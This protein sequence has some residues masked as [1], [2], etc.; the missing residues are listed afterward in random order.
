MR[1]STAW[2]LT[3]T[4]MLIKVRIAKTLTLLGINV[5]HMLAP[6][7]F[8]SPTPVTF[9]TRSPRVSYEGLFGNSAVTLNRTTQ[10]CGP[11]TGLVAQQRGPTWKLMGCFPKW[12]SLESVT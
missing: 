1:V 12:T 9:F 3:V 4:A 6:L 7:P 5:L 11:P 8:T 10:P 2:A